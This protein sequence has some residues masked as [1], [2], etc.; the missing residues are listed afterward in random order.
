MSLVPRKEA[1]K[2]SPRVL[3][4]KMSV[5]LAQ[6]QVGP[7]EFDPEPVLNALTDMRDFVGKTCS[8]LGIESIREVNKGLIEITGIVDRRLE[9]LGGDTRG[10]TANVRDGLRSVGADTIAP[11]RSALLLVAA[12]V[13]VVAASVAAH[14]ATT[15]YDSALARD[16]GSLASAEKI[17]AGVAASIFIGGV[18]LY[19]SLT[20]SARAETTQLQAE[21]SRLRA[22]RDAAVERIQAAKVS[23]DSLKVKSTL[24][25]AEFRTFRN[26]FQSLVR[27]L[28]AKLQSQ[29]GGEQPLMVPAG[30]DFEADFAAVSVAISDL[31]SELIRSPM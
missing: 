13:A 24:V 19:L 4:N 29:F 8:K 25:D 22:E 30:Y 23:V 17:L 26:N 10:A 2:H 28:P 27:P 14:V 11:Y 7:T 20:T 9:Q 5:S 31:R 21:V 3:A 15:A 16:V 18:W 1:S 12:S 6:V